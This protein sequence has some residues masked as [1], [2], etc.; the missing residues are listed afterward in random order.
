[1]AIIT[2]SRQKG[3]LGT[4]IGEVLKKELGYTYFD[5]AVLEEQ[6][7]KKYGI[8][9]QTLARYDEKRPHVWDIFSSSEKEKYLH[10]LKS[11]VYEFAQNGNCIIVGR[12]G[13][14][15]FQDIPG[16]LRVSVVA[17]LQMRIQ[18]I[19]ERFNYDDH[20]AEQ[21]VR[22]S[23]QNRAGFHRFFFHV[24][25]EDC[26]YYD[27]I[28][29]TR[30]LTVETGVQLIKEALHTFGAV[31]K[32]K[33]TEKRIQ[34][35]C[36]GQQVMTRIAYDEKIPL[37]YIQ[38][39]AVGGVITLKGSVST[40]DNIKRIETAARK[41]PGVKDVVNELYVIPLTHSVS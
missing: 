2:I 32:E 7:G 36:L 28:I 35:I 30:A 33:E 23:D 22:Q 24:D 12:G 19:K 37:H 1:M 39:T 34:D 5:Y 21:T 31:A 16:V 10:F 4:L 27:L 29:N 9:K 3:S 40:A 13:Q 8:P 26:D 14:V 20:L 25:W 17:P 41:V 18:R 38:V 11:C 15:L 6:F